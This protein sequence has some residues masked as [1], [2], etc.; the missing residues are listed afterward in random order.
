MEPEV[1]PYFD[2]FVKDC[3]ILYHSPDKCSASMKI[4]FVNE[5]DQEY[6]GY[7]FTNPMFIGN[8][9]TIRIN[10]YYWDLYTDEE[11]WP[12]IY[13]ELGH[14]ILLRQH[15]D[16]WMDTP[17]GPI[18]RSLMHWQAFSPRISSKYEAYYLGELFK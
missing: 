4:T 5:P 11:R 14:A 9:V 1:K 8:L 2:R 13:H 10:K 12:L 6:L 3:K 15:D 17:D 7:A 16:T 18:P